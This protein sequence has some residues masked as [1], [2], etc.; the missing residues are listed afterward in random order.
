MILSL[1]SEADFTNTIWAAQDIYA[2]RPAFYL[3]KNRAP[4][5]KCVYEH[6]IFEPQQKN[7]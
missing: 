5:N 1:S 6:Q 2:L 7:S 4:L 3:Y